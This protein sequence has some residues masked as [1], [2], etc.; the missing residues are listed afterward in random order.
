MQFHP[1]DRFSSIQEYTAPTGCPIHVDPYK[2]SPY[3]LFVCLTMQVDVRFCA[4]D[5]N[6]EFH[7]KLALHNL[8]LS[9]LCASKNMITS[10]VVMLIF[11]DN[12]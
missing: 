9:T 6:N 3:P 1:G 7:V 8:F 10:S 4:F 5:A 12:N 11:S 2:L